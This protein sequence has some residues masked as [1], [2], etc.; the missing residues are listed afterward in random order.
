VKTLTTAAKAAIVAGEAIVTG[1]VEITTLNRRVADVIPTG[2]TFELSWQQ[3]SFDQI[4]TGGGDN[5]Q[6][7]MGYA[8]FDAAGA[9]IGSEAWATLTD[10]VPP[11][12]W[13][14]R[15]LTDTTPAGAAIVRIFQH[16]HRR[17]GVNNDGYIDA[18]DLKLGG[19]SV[20]LDNPGAEFGTGGWVSTQ[21]LLSTRSASPDPY[22]GGAYFFGGAGYVDTTAHQDY[23]T[24]T[25]VGGGDPIRVWGGHGPLTISGDVF[26][27]IGDRGLAQ[28]TAGAIGGVA[29][30]MT[31]GLSG[32]EP[33]VLALLDDAE[34]L[35]GAATVI[36]R[37]IFANDGKT[38]LDAHVFDRGRLDTIDSDEVVGQAAAIT[39]AVESTA[40]S[41]G[42]S[43]ARLRS[44]G[45]QR[46][47][48]SLDGYFAQTAYA[49]QKELY[50]GGK[51]PA[52]TASA[53]G[54]STS[55]GGGGSAALGVSGSSA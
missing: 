11:M 6:A 24:F 48:S 14:E 25:I 8:F 28:Q 42:R 29:Q 45:D 37:L 55:G 1:A 34:D 36:Y 15:T 7:R 41:L 18:I 53:V 44:D 46:L 26:Q 51:K 47:I 33:E 32:I 20:P 19:V 49:W 38:V 21:G 22:A 27:G 52:R 9:M 23:A 3:A 40:R 35:R 50:W 16:M 13:Q 12:E 2:T 54:G 17:T 4:L 43:L 30:G 5:D 10:I 31:L 39:A